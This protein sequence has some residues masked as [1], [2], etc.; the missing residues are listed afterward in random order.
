MT[1]KSIVKVP[2]AKP[3]DLRFLA[4]LSC[5]YLTGAGTVFNVLKPDRNNKVAVLGIGAVGLASLMTYRALGVGCIIAV[6]VVDSK[7]ELAMDLGATQVINTTTTPDL[8]DAIRSVAADGADYIVD[9][10]GVAPLH[11]PAV[12]ALAHEGT[13]ALVGVPPPTASVQINTLD[14]MLS[15]KRLIGVVEGQSYPQEVG[16]TRICY[17]PTSCA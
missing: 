1:E 17:N 3:E 5:G 11:G 7:L 13:L 6:D 2:S 4:P 9:A 14:F 16:E 8:N 15:C 12:K 10:A